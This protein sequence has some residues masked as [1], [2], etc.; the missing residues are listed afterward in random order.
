[1]KL[2]SISGD[3][4]EHFYPF[5]LLQYVE[6]SSF[7]ARGEHL[8]YQF[9]WLDLFGGRWLLLN[10]NLK[11]PARSWADEKVALADL[12]EEGWIITGPHRR[13]LS[14]KNS[15]HSNYGYVVVRTIH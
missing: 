2:N 1:L 11:Y 10:G 3:L 6:R 15:Q 4:F 9:A 14:K 7:S 12:R 5:L 8:M 13:R